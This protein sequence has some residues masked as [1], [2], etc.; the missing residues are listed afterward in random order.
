MKWLPLLLTVLTGCP[1][2]EGVTNLK[3]YDKASCDSEQKAEFKV[4]EGTPYLVC[5]CKDE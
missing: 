1:C 4:F 5:K 3:E 2:L